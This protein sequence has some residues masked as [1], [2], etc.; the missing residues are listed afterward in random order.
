[1]RFRHEIIGKQIIYIKVFGQK[2]SQKLVAKKL[3]T[4]K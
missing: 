3:L 1:M 4:T 2:I